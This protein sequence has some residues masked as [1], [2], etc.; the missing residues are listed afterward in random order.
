MDLY[1]FQFWGAKLGKIVGF[2]ITKARFLVNN[3]IS[4]HFNVDWGFD[5]GL[6]HCIHRSP[7]WGGSR[8]G[9]DPEPWSKSA[10]MSPR[11]GPMS[12]SVPTS[13]TFDQDSGLF[14]PDFHLSLKTLW[15]QCAN[16][17]PKPQSTLKWTEIELL[18]KNRAKACQKPP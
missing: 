5:M 18:T 6:A 3:S 7:N 12:T 14:N 11:S 10:K 16:P 13:V 8:G 17:M 1:D 9:R 15:M 2:E 4:I